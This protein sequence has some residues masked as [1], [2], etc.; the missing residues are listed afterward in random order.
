MSLRVVWSLLSLFTWLSSRFQQFTGDSTFWSFLQGH[1]TGTAGQD[2]PTMLD[3]GKC[4]RGVGGMLRRI[5]KINPQFHFPTLPWAFVPQ[6]TDPANASCSVPSAGFHFSLWIQDFVPKSKPEGGRVM[7]PVSD[8]SFHSPVSSI[9]DLTTIKK[10]RFQAVSEPKTTCIENKM[11]SPVQS[12]LWEWF[13]ICPQPQTAASFSHL[14]TFPTFLQLK[15]PA[16]GSRGEEPRFIWVSISCAG[17]KKFLRAAFHPSWKLG[18]HRWSLKDSI[19]SSA[20]LF[21]IHLQHNNI[22]LEKINLS[23]SWK[24][25]LALVQSQSSPWLLYMT[26]SHFFPPKR[27]AV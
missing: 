4:S 8:R 1:K 12:P 7:A 27:N 5:Q 6:Q 23:D 25:D 16:K 15:H 26:L 10:K 21:A 24:R 2:S 18:S 17:R 3:L 14:W 22:Y 19:Y 13:S 20:A 11:L 9:W